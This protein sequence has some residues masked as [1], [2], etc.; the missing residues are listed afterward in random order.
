MKRTRLFFF[1]LCACL[2]VGTQ[3]RA[4]EMLPTFGDIDHIH[5]PALLV[6]HADGDQTLQLRAQDTTYIDNAQY[7]ETV[8]ATK[9]L[10]QPFYVTLHVR[11]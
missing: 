5:L 4:I 1:A 9:D 10:V 3:M 11:Q 8:I 6:Q 2:M 7:K